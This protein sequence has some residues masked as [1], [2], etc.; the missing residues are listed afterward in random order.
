MFDCFDCFEERVCHEDLV[1]LIKK[2]RGNKKTRKNNFLYLSGINSDGSLKFTRGL[3]TAMNIKHSYYY[4][5]IKNTVRSE[6]IAC[7]IYIMSKFQ[8][9]RLIP[10]ELKPVR[11]ET[12]WN[13]FKVWFSRKFEK[14]MTTP[15]DSSLP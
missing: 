4:D 1:F 11:Q 2:I 13:R 6:K 10:K 9:Y 3:I 14:F 7:E 12:W 5:H 15:I 8:Y